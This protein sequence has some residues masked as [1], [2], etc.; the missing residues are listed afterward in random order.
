MNTFMLI[1]TTILAVF[2]SVFATVLLGQGVLSNIQPIN[3][4]VKL[5]NDEA[6]YKYLGWQNGH[7]L[8]NLDTEQL[9]SV[10]IKPIIKVQSCSGPEDK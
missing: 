3:S 1:R 8:R 6:C 7:I 2:A 5:T 10:F 4:L 9:T